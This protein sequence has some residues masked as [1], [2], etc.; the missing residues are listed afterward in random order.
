MKPFVLPEGKGPEE[1]PYQIREMF[2][3]ADEFKA[4]VIAAMGDNWAA[5]LPRVPLTKEEVKTL[6]RARQEQ[7]EQKVIARLAAL[8]S[9]SAR[10]IT[11]LVLTRAVVREAMR[12]LKEER[13]A[14]VALATILGG[15]R[16]RVFHNNR[17]LATRCGKCRHIEDSF[18]HLIRCYDLQAEYR[19]GAQ[20]V[21][22]L[23]KMA[24]KAVLDPPGV[25]LPFVRDL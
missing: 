4:V 12:D 22:F 17:R 2:R 3:A 24:R 10:I 13:A 20:S 11:D 8:G 18:E 21:D 25:S 7:G 15:T 6:L 23:T 5:T 9:D 19:V 1:M 16:F 14:Q